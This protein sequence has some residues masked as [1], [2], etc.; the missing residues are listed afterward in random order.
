M[1]I[2]LSLLAFERCRPARQSSPCVSKLYTVEDS[3]AGT[4]SFLRRP[5]EGEWTWALTTGVWCT[6]G[7]LFIR[8]LDILTSLKEDERE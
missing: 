1:A 4:G 2:P 7:V 8:L 6:G 5:G 3:M